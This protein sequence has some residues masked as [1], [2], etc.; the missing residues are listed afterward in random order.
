MYLKK[1]ILLLTILLL[2]TGCT[3][4]PYEKR[5]YIHQFEYINFNMFISGW[6]KKD[7]DTYLLYTNKNFTNKDARK[8]V[9]LFCK[10]KYLTLYNMEERLKNK[11]KNIRNTEK[12]NLVDFLLTTND[13]NKYFQQSLKTLN[14]EGLKEKYYCNGRYISDGV[15]L[16]YTEY[17]GYVSIKKYP[18][19]NKVKI[20]INQYVLPVIDEMYKL[21]QKNK[22]TDS[23]EKYTKMVS[24]NKARK[25]K[26]KRHYYLNK[27]TSLNIESIVNGVDE[28]A[29]IEAL[30]ELIVKVAPKTLNYKWKC[31]FIDRYTILYLT[32][33]ENKCEVRTDVNINFDATCRLRSSKMGNLTNCSIDRIYK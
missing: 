12:K 5:K 14:L 13:F 25:V 16:I 17:K 26:N 19:P 31:K 29:T 33:I 4:N 8:Q 28:K 6:E 23:L 24:V 3:L 7:K 20:D 21:I 27:K 10:S 1:V 11:L 30:S 2:I 18:K 22:D 32:T 15:F 9:S